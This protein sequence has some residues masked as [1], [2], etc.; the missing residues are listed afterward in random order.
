MKS[1]VIYWR[2][3]LLFNKE[4]SKNQNIDENNYHWRR[5]SSYLQN[6]LRNFIDVFR[7]DVNYDNIKSYKKPGL[8]RLSRRYIWEK[9]TWEWVEVTSSSTAYSHNCKQYVFDIYSYKNLLDFAFHY[10]MALKSFFA[11]KFKAVF[12]MMF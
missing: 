10:L 6:D 2:H 1:F 3:Y 8:H 7:K 9:T 12:N 4:V 11:N 5:K